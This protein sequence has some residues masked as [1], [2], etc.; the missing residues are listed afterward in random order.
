MVEPLHWDSLTFLALEAGFQWCKK[1]PRPE[2]SLAA[3]D[4]R[5]VF[6]AWLRPSLSTKR[7]SFAFLAVGSY[8]YTSNIIR[9]I[10]RRRLHMLGYDR[11]SPKLTEGFTLF[12]YPHLVY[13]LPVEVVTGVWLLLHVHSYLEPQVR[14]ACQ[15]GTNVGRPPR[16]EQ[17]ATLTEAVPLNP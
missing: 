9:P 3:V 17:H 12:G 10:C 5:N 2:T 16:R 6:S 11:Q 13:S 8:Y 14:A 1:L 7:C 4:G 15:M